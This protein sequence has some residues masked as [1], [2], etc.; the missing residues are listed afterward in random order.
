[1]KESIGFL[2]TQVEYS[3]IK[4]N[5]LWDPITDN[6]YSE[7]LNIF[8]PNG[9]KFNGN[10]LIRKTRHIDPGTD[11]NIELPLILGSGSFHSTNGRVVGN[12]KSE[13]KSVSKLYLY[14]NGSLILSYVIDENGSSPDVINES[15]ILFHSF[16]S[17]TGDLLI[18]FKISQSNVE[19]KIVLRDFI[20][21]DYISTEEYILRDDSLE[22]L[23]KEV[24]LLDSSDLCGFLW[25][26][27]KGVILP[28]VKI[29]SGK[30]LVEGNFSEIDSIEII[31]DHNKVLEQDILT[32]L[33]SKT[34]PGD[35]YVFHKEEVY[36]CLFIIDPIKKYYTE[37]SGFLEFD[38]GSFY[39]CTINPYDFKKRI[40]DLA[41][42]SI[43]YKVRLN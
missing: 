2:D 9:G 7:I 36:H 25:A 20:L 42:D 12:I 16:D 11:E 30:T 18:D 32:D 13:S 8:F 24:P 33:L 10:V 29:F 23:T 27:N 21:T 1:M 17:K 40:S 5:M 43:F 28:N 14:H 41:I 31:S 22:Y 19:T 15:I 38:L 37:C 39:N 35:I 26:A 6:V 4:K 34:E 3:K